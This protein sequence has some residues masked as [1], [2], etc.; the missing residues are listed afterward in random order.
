VRLAR[1]VLRS[2][3]DAVD[4]ARGDDGGM[5]E[6]AP[7]PLADVAVG[8]AMHRG[9]IS[10]TPATALADVARTMVEHRV[11]CVVVYAERDGRADEETVWG[12]VSD[13]DL[14]AAA[15]RGG[16]ALA[17][18]ALAAAPVVTVSP[19]DT[20]DRVAQLMAE[21][22]AAHLIVADDVD[23]LPIGIVSSLDVARALA[24]AQTA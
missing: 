7:S 24:Q 12:V 19:T 10:C 8:S 11:H 9:L 13:L 5:T 17:A 15:S 14:V 21:H 18:G 22:Q 4:G 20:L 23:G 3:P 2:D 1:T 6:I 16:P